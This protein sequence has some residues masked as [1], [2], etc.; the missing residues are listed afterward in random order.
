MEVI[1]PKNL[2]YALERGFRTLRTRGYFAEQNWQCCQSCGCRAV[3]DEFARRYV[4]YHAQDADDLRE[5]GETRIAWAG[6]GDE[7]VEVFR[8]EGLRVEWNGSQ[9]RR[10]LISALVLN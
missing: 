5:H 10:I 1:M 6:D 2:Q 4:F 3:P 7:I 9:D 8:A